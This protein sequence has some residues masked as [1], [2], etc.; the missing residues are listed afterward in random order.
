MALHR[1]PAGDAGRH[2]AA[3]LIPSTAGWTIAGVVLC[4]AAYLNMALLPSALVLPATAIVLAMIGFATAAA[5]YLT[6][7]RM[8]HEGTTGWDAAASLVFFGFAAALLTNTGDGMAAVNAL[9]AR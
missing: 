8:G 5:L 1:M 2:R 4:V 7:H 6:G 3:G 9:T